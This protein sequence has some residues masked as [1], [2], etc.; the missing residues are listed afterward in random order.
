MSQ[1][2]DIVQWNTYCAIQQMKTAVDWINIYSLYIIDKATTLCRTGYADED[3][4]T[5]RDGVMFQMY[6]TSYM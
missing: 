6:R 2:W 3:I 1:N 4:Q 5:S